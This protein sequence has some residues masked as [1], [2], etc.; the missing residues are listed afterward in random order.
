MAHSLVDL[1]VCL[2]L[3][4]F[5][6]VVLDTPI[7]YFYGLLLPEPFRL[8]WMLSDLSIILFYFVLQDFITGLLP[9][10]ADISMSALYFLPEVLN[11]TVQGISEGITGVM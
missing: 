7:F 2:S 11:L 3:S 10:F 5:L 9:V 8:F 6:I 4:C 1:Q